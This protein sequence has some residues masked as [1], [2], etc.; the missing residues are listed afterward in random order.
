VLERVL[1][2]PKGSIQ[3]MTAEALKIWFS[4]D[5]TLRSETFGE[6]ANMP[7]SSNP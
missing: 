3:F 2:A 1:G 6:E 4:S 7:A 5:D